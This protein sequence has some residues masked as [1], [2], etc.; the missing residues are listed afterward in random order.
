MAADLRSWLTAVG[1]PPD[2]PLTA[3]QRGLGA[4]EIWKLEPG[5]GE[6]PLAVRLFGPGQDAAAQREAA[7]M[8]TARAGGVPTP[9]ILA[10]GSVDDRPVMVTSFVPGHLAS[11]ALFATPADAGTLGTALGEVLG[12]LH[13]QPAPDFGRP[14]GAWLDLAGDAITPLRPVLAAL[15]VQDRLLHLDYHLL[16]VMVAGATVTGVIDWENATAGPPHAD[17]ARSMAIGRMAVLS[18]AVPAAIR[19]AVETFMASLATAHDRIAGPSPLPGALEAWG[20]AMTCADLRHQ[21]GKAGSPVSAEGFARLEAARD[22]AIAAA[23]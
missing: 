6:Q 15:P 1:Y 17:L 20:L 2:R 16:N 21:V 5:A 19:P 7:A 12:R 11:E 3:L 23:R 18:G 14:A 4:N 13:L 8:R 10:T 22:A 9:E